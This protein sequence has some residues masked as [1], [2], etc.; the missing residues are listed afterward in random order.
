VLYDIAETTNLQRAGDNDMK[1]ARFGS[2][3]TI[4]LSTILLVFL[5][6]LAGLRTRKSEVTVLARTLFIN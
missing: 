1:V 2:L 6:G 5:W 4:I 3:G